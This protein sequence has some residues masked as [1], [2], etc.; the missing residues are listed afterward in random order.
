[1]ILKNA[2][3]MN[4]QFRLVRADVRIK[5]GIIEEISEN[6]SGDDALDLSG[7]YILPGFIDTHIHGAYGVRI[8]DDGAQLE[9]MT[10]F[11]A[12]QGVTSLAVTTAAS[13]FEGILKQMQTIKASAGCCKGAKI[14]GAHAEGPFISRKYKGAMTEEYILQPDVDKLARMIEEGRGLIKIL[15][16]APELDGA[17]E[18]IRFAVS[19]GIAVSMGHTDASYD[20]AVKAIEAGATRMTHTFNAARPINHR[21]PG[22]LGAAL[23]DDRITCEMI[24]DYVHLHPATVEMI[25]RLKGADRINMISDSGHAA[26][27]DITEFEVDGV[28][29][30]VKDKTVRLAN[31][32]IAGSAMTLY[33]GVKNLI[34]SGISINDVSKMASLSPARALGIDK[35]TGSIEVGKLADL[36]VLDSVYNVEK[37]FVNGKCVFG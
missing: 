19:N 21:E 27:L 8:S 17:E 31:G 5:N 1:M 34:N 2:N 23:T 26:G 37:T 25:Y 15:T 16:V 13:R 11:E 12:S 4:G 14:V 29:R 10:E 33:D 20:A 3:V 36:V 35:E 22:V 9:T 30:Y 6:I 32:T 7:K 24:C 18:L 28:M